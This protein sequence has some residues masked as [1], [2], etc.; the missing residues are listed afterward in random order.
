MAEGR[1]KQD[2]EAYLQAAE[3]KAA[4]ARLMRS[5]GKTAKEIAN[6]LGVTRMTISRYLRDPV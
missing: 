2:R 1:Y 5:Q 4:T 3:N 6:E